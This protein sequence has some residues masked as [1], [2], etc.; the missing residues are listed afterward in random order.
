MKLQNYHAF[1]PQLLPHMNNDYDN[2]DIFLVMFFH[3]NWH[4]ILIFYNNKQF[5][6]YLLSYVNVQL[7]SG[8]HVYLSGQVLYG[9]KCSHSCKRFFSSV[10]K[11]FV[12]WTFVDNNSTEV[13]PSLFVS[14]CT[15]LNVL[16][17]ARAD[18]SLKCDYNFFV[19]G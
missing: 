2:P 9:P 11:N 6:C 16:E 15:G 3:G 4:L 14:C 8:C 10:H 12:E 19:T 17:A 7:N 18:V 13:L 1:R 5:A